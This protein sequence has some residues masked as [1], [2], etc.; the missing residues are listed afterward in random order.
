MHFF[1]PLL[2][3]AL[4]TAI[5]SPVVAEENATSNAACDAVLQALQGM[6]AAPHY[7]WKMSATT[8]A[9]RR[10]VEREQVV[11]DDMVYMT[12]DEGR[13]M[14][15]RISLAERA[16]RVADEV[17]Q[18]PI[19]SCHLLGTEGVGR[20]AMAIYGYRQGV[21]TAAAGGDGATKRIWIGVEDGLPHLFKSDEGLVSVTMQV[22]YERVQTP[23]P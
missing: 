19:S 2:T 8:P 17:A 11:L 15:Q 16:A 6:G 13:W 20:T 1:L 5:G 12:P 7:H 10:P 4:V 21:Q 18:H 14:K 22:D 23:L 3:L 9:R